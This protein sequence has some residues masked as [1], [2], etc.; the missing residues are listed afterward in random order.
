MQAV[1][2]NLSICHLDL[3]QQLE[4]QEYPFPKYSQSRSLAG[5]SL[6]C[7]IYNEDFIIS[8]S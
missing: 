7:G 6:L 3:W 8:H 4:N 5:S 1:L 2:S